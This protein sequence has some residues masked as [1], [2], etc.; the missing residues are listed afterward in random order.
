VNWF[1]VEQ[2]KAWI[3][4]SVPLLDHISKVLSLGCDSCGNRH[5]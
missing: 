1:S 5:G 2:C 4:C 3:C